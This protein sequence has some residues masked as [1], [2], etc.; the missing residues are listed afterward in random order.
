MQPRWRHGDPRWG[1]LQAAPWEGALAWFHSLGL[2]FASIP[3]FNFSF[4]TGLYLQSCYAA[5]V[6]WNL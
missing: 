5:Q 3:C 2:C 1:C 6:G 4:R